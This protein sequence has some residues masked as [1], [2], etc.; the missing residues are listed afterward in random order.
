MTTGGGAPEVHTPTLF[1]AMGGG[2]PGA[3]R[4]APPLG[5]PPEA[6]GPPD[7]AARRRITEELTTTLFVEAG[8][9]SG[10]TAALVDRVT[11]LVTGGAV[12]LDQLAAITFTDK[13]GAELRDRIR[14]R[15][16]ELGDH[17][18]D[19]TRARCHL[20]LEQLDG[21]AIGTLHAFA[22]RLLS[23]HPVEAGLP[24]RVEVLDEVSSAVA[25]ERRWSAYLDA[26][27]GDPAL[28]RTL[29]LLRA[30]G[31]RPDALRTLADAFDANWDLVL[32]RVPTT[33]PEPPPVAALLAPVL[34]RLRAVCAEQCTDPADK[35]R[36]RLDDVAAYAGSLASLAD[37]DDEIS[38]LGAL[39]D[40]GVPERPSFRVTRCGQKCN[41]PDIESVRDALRDAGEELEAVRVAVGEACAKRIGSAVRAFT[42]DAANERRRAGELEFHD[43]LVLARSL[44]RH[45]EHGA[46][47]RRR[48]HDRYRRLLLDEFQDTDP[49]Q[50]EL[51]VRIAAAEPGT[52]AAGSAPWDAVEVGPGRLFVVGDPKQSIY[53]FR[54]ADIATFL[55][56]ARRFGGDDGPVELTANFRTAGPLVDW[57]NTT[58]ATLM[59]GDGGTG[60]D[61][62]AGEDA[63]G[64]GDAPV[65][66]QPRYIALEATRPAPPNGPA[67]AVLGRRAHD[68]TARADELRSAEAAEVAG[69][70]ARVVSE[71]WDV[72]DGRGGWRPARLGDVAVL[73]PAR[74]SLPF[75]EDAFER[76]GIAFRAESSSLVYATRA[77]RDLLMVLRAVDD[78][79]DH[80]RVL[81]ALRT[82]LFGCGDDDLFRFRVERGGRWGFLADQ[83]DTVP[84]Q[85]PVRTALEYLRARHHER[86]VAA[87][88]ELLE[89]IAR[90]RRAFELGFAEGRPRDVW[91]RLRYVVDQARAWSD[92]TGGTLRQYLR[93]VQL[94]TTEGARLAESVLPERDDDAVRVMTIHSAKGLEFPVTVVSGMSSAPGGRRAP[95]DVVFPTHTESAGYRFGARVTTDEYR[96]WA[97][98]DELMEYHERIRLLY[99]A[100]TRARDHLVVSLHRK[101][102]AT[103]PAAGRATNAELLAGAMEARLD[104]LPD[105]AVAPE[106][107]AAVVAPAPAPPAPFA[108]WEEELGRALAAAHRPAA[109]AAT[110]L[111]EEGAPDSEGAPDPGLQKR[112]VDLDLPPWRKGRY[113]TAVG[114]AV[115]GVLQTVDLATGA[116]LDEAV[117]AQ[118]EAEAVGERAGEVRD[119]AGAALGSASVRLAARHPHWREVYACAPVGGRLLE[120]YVD[121]LV[122]APEGLVV[123]D[124]KTS[125]T[126]DPDE[127]DRRV[128]GY[129]L[130]GASYALALGLSTGE[131]V[132]RVTF[133]F[134]TP[135]GAVERH[136]PDLEAATTEVAALVGAGR[137]VVVD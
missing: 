93:W 78:P 57:I 37:T 55:R 109:V 86:H 127:L 100:C 53:R 133:L 35:L 101:A 121:L 5:T 65:P 24:P 45:P 15:L 103:P 26:M 19:Q 9:G 123:V 13:A 130:Q 4:V 8:A 56:A 83:P 79:T 41:W 76:A 33:A 82:P 60:N 135:A 43:L 21:A 72:D 36:V 117:A 85:D 77:V 63:A 34:A 91:K 113:G 59:R 104:E 44:L 129:R 61:G 47:V 115:H 7:A 84:P 25:F 96:D 98:I 40:D 134:L 125:A 51:A 28:E 27:L 54:R 97:P 136:L 105:A 118:C 124:H 137:E 111:T 23:E 14:R 6:P 120:G 39:G 112:P 20:A 132:V 71:G 131:P 70:V 31:V 90:D 68:G 92:A 46:A 107:L 58:F 119:L 88:S 1:E 3:G 12:E 69:A 108:A 89:R 38:L 42:L 17:G 29:L 11:A 74:T 75:L 2:D 99:V 62:G 122:R 49:I 22:Q 126:D 80:L 110:A 95:V 94:Q 87:P 106:V 67:V 32:E 102:R 114:R 16:E 18:D 116:G 10:K 81:S 64:T 73:V 66:S 30:A 52:A 128:E 50:V 48:L